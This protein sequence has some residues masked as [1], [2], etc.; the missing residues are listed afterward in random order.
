MNIQ[1]VIRLTPVYTNEYLVSHLPDNTPMNIMS[2][3]CLT[4]V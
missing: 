3:I 2:E 1:S 4:H